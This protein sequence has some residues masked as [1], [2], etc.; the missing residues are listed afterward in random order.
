M[1][2]LTHLKT[3]AGFVKKENKTHS[4]LVV[5]KFI[6]SC[7]HLDASIFEPCMEEDDVFE[8]LEKYTFLAELKEL[9]DYS[10]LKT[11]NNFT[12][13]MSN[14][15]C[16]RCEPGKPVVNFDIMH[17]KTKLLV[18][19]FGFLFDM[20]NDILKDIFRCHMYKECHGRWL[21]PDGLLAIRVT[22]VGN[23]KFNRS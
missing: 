5:D 13:S 2:T 10:K 22:D 11:D 21:R 18:G 6:E 9:F 4:Q 14:E 12:V 3:S 20:E 16:M 7:Q 1:E 15:K 17:A 8:D 23:K 19:D